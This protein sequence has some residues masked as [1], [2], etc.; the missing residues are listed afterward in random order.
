MGAKDGPSTTSSSTNL[1]W[2]GL[3]LNQLPGGRPA[4]IFLSHGRST[5]ALLNRPTRNHNYCCE[6]FP[7]ESLEGKAVP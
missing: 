3:G 5:S 2:A 4:T 1:I 7:I 6:A